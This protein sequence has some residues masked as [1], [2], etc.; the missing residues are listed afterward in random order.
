MPYF[1]A[2]PQ[3][4]NHLSQFANSPT[5]IHSIFYVQEKTFSIV[6]IVPKCKMITIL[7]YFCGYNCLSV[8]H[9]TTVSSTHPVWCKFAQKRLRNL[10]NDEG[11]ARRIVFRHD[12]ALA[13]KGIDQIGRVVWNSH[14]DIHKVRAQSLF[15]GLE[16]Q[17]QSFTLTC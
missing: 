6:W 8:E 17:I 5:P 12:N 1:N 9:S 2:F 13:M 11:P 14:A 10:A 16:Q 4:V 7:K 3:N 15:H